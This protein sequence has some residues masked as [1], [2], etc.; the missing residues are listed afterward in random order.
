MWGGYLHSPISLH[1]LV[2]NGLSTGA[3]LYF[4]GCKL[5]GR[6]RNEYKSLVG[7]PEDRFG[8]LGSDGMT[9]VE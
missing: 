3:A 1:G 8:N 2:R 7:E 4:I 6:D 9:L 5:Y